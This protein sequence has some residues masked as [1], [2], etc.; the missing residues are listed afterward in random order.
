MRKFVVTI[1]YNGK[2]YNGWQKNANGKSVQGEIEKALALLFSQEIEAIG[3]SRT[4]SGVSAR[5]YP[6]CFCVDTKLPT[7][8]IPYKL[9]RFLP[10]DIQAYDVKEVAL[11]FDLRKSVQKKTYV[12]S[13]YVSPHVLPLINPTAYKV[14]NFN[15]DAVK[16]AM[17]SLVGKHDLTA[18][19]T[20][21]GDYTSPIKTIYSATLEKEGC[22]YK[23]KI[24]GDGFGYNTIRIIAGTLLKIS[25]SGNP[26][27]FTKIME[28]KN[29]QNAGITLPPKG[30]ILE[31]VEIK[32]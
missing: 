9:N 5:E 21:G 10:K 1:Q 26:S 6:V 30:L 27:D 20:V 11:D 28:S 15:E 29:R 12:Y 18:F 16:T 7:E 25:E 23:M 13:I 14:D 32:Y 4:D 2:N 3:A 19:V 22:V 24:C 31:S 17:Q 8:R